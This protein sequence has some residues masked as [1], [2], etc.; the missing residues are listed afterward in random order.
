MFAR[1]QYSD[2]GTC[3]RRAR[4]FNSP[5]IVELSA[6]QDRRRHVDLWFESRHH[7]SSGEVSSFVASVN[8][9]RGIARRWY[10]L[11]VEKF[12]RRGEE[13]GFFHA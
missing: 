12:C 11:R 6:F 2:L 1:Q 10:P 5:P 7:H 8:F 3:L 13:V 9:R 4:N